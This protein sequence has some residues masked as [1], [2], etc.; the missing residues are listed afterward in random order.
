[1]YYYLFNYHVLKSQ[2]LLRENGEMPCNISRSVTHIRQVKGSVGPENNGE[3]GEDEFQD[4]ELEGAE[5]EQ[6]EG[7]SGVGTEE[8]F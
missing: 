7:A 2:D 5:F 1:M 8:T 4:G 3:D 6:E